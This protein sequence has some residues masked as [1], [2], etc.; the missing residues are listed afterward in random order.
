M[1]GSV[2]GFARDGKECLEESGKYRFKLDL[3]EWV[4]LTS[5]LKREGGICQG[6]W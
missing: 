6:Q 2:C 1:I 5:V 3:E 4:N